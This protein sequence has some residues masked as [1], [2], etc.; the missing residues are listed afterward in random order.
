M[1]FQKKYKSNSISAFLS[2]MLLSPRGFL[3]NPYGKSELSSLD[4]VDLNSYK[5]WHNFSELHNADTVYDKVFLI[6][7]LMP[8]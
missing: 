3:R 8:L 1:K 7:C 5:D 4:C 2:R 6:V